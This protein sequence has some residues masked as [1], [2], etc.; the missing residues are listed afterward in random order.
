[1][2]Y[3]QLV[4]SAQDGFERVV[5]SIPG[6]KGYKQKELRR[7]ADKLLRNK[8]AG[9]LNKQLR[10]LNAQQMALF[11]AGALEYTD[12]LDQAITKLQ[13]LS[14]RVKTASYGYRGFFDAVKVK[15]E[16]LGALYA[17]DAKLLAGVPEIAQAIDRVADAIQNKTEIGAAIQALMAAVTELG[18]LFAKR[19]EAIYQAGQ[20]G[21]E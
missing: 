15:E 13:T 19:E 5:G 18:E 1:M 7:E 16:Q 17:F 9:E 21:V 11:K 4:E 14:D 20:A 3:Q 2:D 10:R 8:I 12:D 6:Y